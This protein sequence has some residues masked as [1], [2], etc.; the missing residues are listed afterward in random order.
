MGGHIIQLLKLICNFA[1]LM[2]NMSISIRFVA[3]LAFLLAG[4]MTG[5][6]Q[7]PFDIKRKD[8]TRKETPVQ[9][10]PVPVEQRAKPVVKKNTDTIASKTNR[11]DSL[12]P[13]PGQNGS[14]Q[15]PFDLNA[16]PAGSSKPVNPPVLTNQDIQATDHPADTP[17]ASESGTPGNESMEPPQTSDKSVE[18]PSLPKEKAKEV[19][20]YFERIVGSVAFWLLFVCLLSVTAVVNL[21][22]SFMTELTQSL[23]SEN[24]FRLTYREFSKGISQYLHLAMYAVFFLQGALF[25]HFIIK[26]WSTFDVS[27]WLIL[28]VFFCL[29]FAKHFVLW[30]LSVLF[31]VEKE[32]AQYS[33]STMQFN[34]FLGLVFFAINWLLAFGPVNLHNGLIMTGIGAFAILYVMRQFRGLLIGV[35]LATLYKFQFFLYLCAIE[36][37]PIL[38]IYRQI[39]LQLFS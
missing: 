14:Q 25:I 11:K 29:Y 9:K 38:L 22:R 1:G 2:G 26:Y 37:G 27:Y 10:I 39:S 31:P 13:S 7:N 12:P 4:T 17:V 5:L 33:F 19:E 36:I 32:T 24:F 18:T 3:I 34:I 21:N 6:A 30:M 20:N 16:R 28:G 35:R 15:N 8:T 23:I